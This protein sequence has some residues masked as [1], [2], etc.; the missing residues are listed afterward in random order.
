MIRSLHLFSLTV[1]TGPLRATII[2]MWLRM[3]KSFK[4]PILNLNLTKV[5]IVSTSDSRFVP[6]ESNRCVFLCSI[7]YIYN[8]ICTFNTNVM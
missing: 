4:P 5:Q 7:L 3:K 6:I 2:L 8:N 1:T